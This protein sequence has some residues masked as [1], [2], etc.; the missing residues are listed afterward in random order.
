MD[1][2]VVT[3]LEGLDWHDG[4]S[5]TLE[6]QGWC[7]TESPYDR[8]PARARGAVRDPVWELGRHSAGLCLRFLSDAGSLAVRWTLRSESLAMAH[9]PATGVSGVDLYARSAG[10]TW[11]WLGMGVPERHPDNQRQVATGLPVGECEFLLYLPLY[12]GV[13]AVGP[14]GP[15]GRRPLPPPPRPP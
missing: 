15:P 10:G 14:G 5:L 8:L 11:R 13:T 6:G 7:D 3:Y 9:M 2:G 1:D 12:N 4:A